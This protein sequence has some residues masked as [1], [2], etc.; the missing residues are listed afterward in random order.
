MPFYRRSLN[1]RNNRI[2]GSSNIVSL[3][4]RVQLPY[5]MSSG[6]ISWNYN[7]EDFPSGSLT[8]T[9]VLPQDLEGF[10]EA[11]DY[12][13]K[14]EAIATIEGI[15]YFCQRPFSY[16][17]SHYLVSDVNVEVFTIKVN[18]VSIYGARAKRKVFVKD[19][20]GGNNAVTITALASFVDVPYK[21]P[22]FVIDLPDQVAVDTTISLF[23]AVTEQA[24]ILG[25]YIRCENGIELVKVG[26]GARFRFAVGEVLNADGE[27]SISPPPVY[28]SSELTWNR[29]PLAPDYELKEPKVET[30]IRQDKDPERPPVSDFGV[31]GQVFIKAPWSSM[32][33][34]GGPTKTRTITTTIDGTPEKVVTQIYGYT[35]DSRNID[36]ESETIS[37]AENYWKLCEETTTQ[38]IYAKIDLPSY[39]IKVKDLSNPQQPT[40]GEIAEFGDNTVQ[41]IKGIPHPDY[42]RFAQEN[43]QGGVTLDLG[44]QY[45]VQEKTTG[46]KRV[47]LRQ[48]KGFELAIAL[49]EL[50]EVGG[51]LGIDT[52]IYLYSGDD[53]VQLEAKKAAIDAVSKLTGDDAADFQDAV[54]V[55][56]AFEQ[57]EVPT[58]SCKSY[59]LKNKRGLYGAFESQLNDYEQNF[60]SNP[61]TLDVRN[62]GALSDRLKAGIPE[63]PG[64]V[65]YDGRVVFIVPDPSYVEPYVISEEAFLKGTFLFAP[66]PESLQDDIDREGQVDTTGEESYTYVTR[67]V[68]AKN[69]YT[70]LN[71]SYSSRESGFE[72]TFTK[73]DESEVL[74]TLPDAQTRVAK[75][76]DRDRKVRR[77]DP[78]RKTRYILESDYLTDSSP[79][80]ESAGFP[81]A[82]S[83]SAAVRAAET[84][85]RIKTWQESNQNKTCAWYYP[86]L[87]PGDYISTPRDLFAEIGNWR[88]LNASF[89]INILGDN[90]AKKFKAFP[91]ALTQGTGIS[92]GLDLPRRIGVREEPDARDRQLGEDE[93]VVGLTGQT[94]IG[95][96][97]LSIQT[98][99]NLEPPTT[100]VEPPGTEAPSRGE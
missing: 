80:G 79:V 15:P 14:Q 18:L 69:R 28:N 37:S 22:N 81:A 34:N 13:G 75:W 1:K 93:V 88:L 12:L 99:R 2:I 73:I 87:R 78:T 58:E 98:R 55:F 35:F 10:E 61:F 40:A 68:T 96:I 49:E 24:R 25:C 92:T 64:Y 90:N 9:G 84:D 82:D 57:K 100:P 17:R 71:S 89:S 31:D 39:D 42:T 41:Y 95:E 4:G 65:G 8:Y 52:G 91:I 6:D 45:L 85:L 70:E 23:E 43:D 63:E 54:G 86:S 29:D 62:Y 38:F 46:W 19:F 32:F 66:T 76:E 60:V 16:E 5:P 21:G 56:N 53:P 44:V 30:I 33:I 47:A 3:R 50:T 48:E 7:F 74:G 36:E 72:R 26:D 11:F 97:I 83:I 59:L 27:N 67:T 77:K 20:N 51:E 94:T